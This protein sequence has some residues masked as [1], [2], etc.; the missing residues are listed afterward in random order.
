[1]ITWR[2]A[3]VSDARMLAE[4]RK[5]VWTETYRGI[6]PDEM[7]DCYDVD[8]YT[9]RDA[10]RIAD[11]S[12]HFYLFL[13]DE[14]CVGY[15]SYGPSNFGPYKDFDLCLNNLYIREN[16]KGRGLGKAAFANIRE[17]CRQNGI[18]K[19]FCGCNYHN[20]PAMGFY[21]HMGGVQGDTV[22]FHDSKADDIVHFEFTGDTL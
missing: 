16:Y 2:K 9:K 3:E 19:F 6:F 14:E 22:A 20:T 11:P 7:L 21:A 10:G 17:Y 15:F 12:H 5:T 1:M 4:T 18:E 8:A 13:L